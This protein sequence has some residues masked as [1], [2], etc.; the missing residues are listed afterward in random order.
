MPSRCV[1][2]TFY[3]AAKITGC[4]ECHVVAGEFDNFIL[5]RPQDS[6]SFNRLHAEQLLYLLGVRQVRALMVLRSLFLRPSCR[7][8]GARLLHF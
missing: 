3:P 7:W 5:I 6:E 1:Y 8:P 2:S 4:M